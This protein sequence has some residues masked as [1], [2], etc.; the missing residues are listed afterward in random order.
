MEIGEWLQSNM[1]TLLSTPVAWLG[2]VIGALMLPATKAR[3]TVSALIV[4]TILLEIGFIGWVV[5][6]QTTAAAAPRRPPRPTPTTQPSPRPS[7]SPPAK[8]PTPQTSPEA[9]AEAE[10][11]GE[12]QFSVSSKSEPSI[13]KDYC[14]EG[15]FEGEVGAGSDS[16]NID[17]H[18]ANFDLCTDS[19]VGRR[20]AQFQV[21]VGK[22]QDIRSRNTK[23][24]IWGKP[25]TGT[26]TAGQPLNFAP[27]QVAFKK[28]LL[29]K[30][31][32][33]ASLS[34][35]GIIFRVYNKERRGEYFLSCENVFPNN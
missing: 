8:A 12:V 29:G 35:Y 34:G 3:R 17:I 2:L 31:I 11:S 4:F 32:G 33:R 7:P 19:K 21:G 23:A 14:L 6:R 22:I 9:P 27:R 16:I 15:E 10:D 1:Q 26:I 18:K 24:I 25:V 13:R 28:T 20:E 5:Y 30:K